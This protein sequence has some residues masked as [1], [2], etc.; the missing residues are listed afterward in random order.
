MDAATDETFRKIV[1]VEAPAAPG[2]QAWKELDDR[3]TALTLKQGLLKLHQSGELHTDDV[4]ALTAGLSG[5]MNE[6]SLW[7]A[8][9]KS[10]RSA[11]PRAKSVTTLLL[12]SFR[13][14]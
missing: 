4:D 5:A 13:R 3:T 12:R 14:E 6:L 8:A 10:P 9:E 7:V 11:L 2:W 1:L